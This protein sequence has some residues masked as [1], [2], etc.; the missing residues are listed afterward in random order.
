[1]PG[2]SPSLVHPADFNG[3]NNFAGR[4]APSPAPQGFPGGDLFGQIATTALNAAG[5]LLNSAGGKGGGFQVGGGG[6]RIQLAGN[7]SGDQGQGAPLGASG[8]TLSNG[9]THSYQGPVDQSTNNTW[10]IKPST[11]PQL[12]SA[13]QAHANSLRDN[14]SLASAP[15]TLMSYP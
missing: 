5:G 3:P 15:G 7:G 11:D 9:V 14:S 13:M 2:T 8:M 6:S 12:V 1:M 10:N 4:Y